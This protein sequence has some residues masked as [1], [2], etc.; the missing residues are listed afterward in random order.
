MAGDLRLDGSQVHHGETT[1]RARAVLDFWFALPPDRHFAR[2]DE[3]DRAI[4]ERFAPWIDAA[5]G[6]DAADCW[7][8]PDTLL[9]T[10]VL[11]DQFTRNSRRG[12]AAAFAGD[13]LARRLALHAIALEWDRAYP[14]ERRLFAYL[15]LEHAEDRA[16]QALS[17]AKYEELGI[18][19]NLDYAR[20]HRD[21]IERYGR[22]PSRNAALGRTSTADE[23]EYLSRPGAGW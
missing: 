19:E 22:F 10:I 12:T 23:E 1:R 17:V 21:V 11:L 18:A 9:G 7:D 6:T 13:P 2:D 15:P 8:D 16:L 3:L 20:Q 14:P 5:I 4:G